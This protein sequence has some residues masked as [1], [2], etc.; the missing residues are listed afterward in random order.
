M[1]ALERITRADWNVRYFVLCSYYVLIMPPFFASHPIW[2]LLFTTISRFPDHHSIDA[3]YWIS[4]RK[5]RP[6]LLHWP[7]PKFTVTHIVV[8]LPFNISTVSLSTRISQSLPLVSYFFFSSNWWLVLI[9][10]IPGFNLGPSPSGALS[11]PEFFFSLCVTIHPVNFFLQWNLLLFFFQL[12]RRNDEFVVILFR[13]WKID[14]TRSRN[15]WF[16][17]RWTAGNEWLPASKSGGS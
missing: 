8:S 12:W 6:H 2:C 16:F 1:I 17:F 5:Y 7:S 11:N 14:D 3:S 9:S 4:W 10:P 13:E 15:P